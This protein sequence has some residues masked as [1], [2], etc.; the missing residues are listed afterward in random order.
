MTTDILIRSYEKDFGWLAYCLLSCQ[1]RAH[2][3]RYIH[4]V[5]PTA[6]M[7]SVPVGDD[8]RVIVHA[9]EDYCVGYNT[10]QITKLNADSYSDADFVCH[11]DSDCIWTEDVTPEDFFKEGKPIIFREMGDESPWPP[12]TYKA[13]GWY[14]PYDYMRRFPFVYPRDIYWAFRNWFGENKGVSVENYIVNHPNL[15]HEKFLSVK[16]SDFHKWEYDYGWRFS[17]FNT[18]GAWAHKCWHDRFYWGAANEFPM[19]VRQWWSYNVI[20]H[21][22]Q[23]VEDLLK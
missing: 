7:G 11:L 18:L 9:T 17:E 10:Q 22:R 1:K 23:E 13:L 20:D 6:D 16:F 8:P 5:V 21:H 19:K 14:D 4:I 2:G 3:F 15:K 12:I